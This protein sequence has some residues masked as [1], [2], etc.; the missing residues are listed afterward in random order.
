MHKDKDSEEARTMANDLHLLDIRA[1][2]KKLAR[3][4]FVNLSSLL[5]K[6]HEIKYSSR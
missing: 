2:L 3:W 1:L 4:A 6:I 5:S